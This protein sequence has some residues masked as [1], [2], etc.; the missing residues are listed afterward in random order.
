MAGIPQLQRRV[1]CENPSLLTTSAI[2]FIS[3]SGSVLS[4]LE[5][6]F[7]WHCCKLAARFIGPGA[8]RCAVRIGTD[9]RMNV[10]LSDPYWSRLIASS[11][12]YEAD[13]KKILLK[14]RDLDFVVIDGGANFGYWSILLSGADL[15]RH[16]V[17]AVEAHPE[18]FRQL[19]ENCNP[20]R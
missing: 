13:F 10:L 14:L 15:G 8:G 5:H 20:E 17:I 3:L 4:L 11:Y 12:D 1:M 18:T 19:A 6:R 16:Q 9:S 7:F 2:A